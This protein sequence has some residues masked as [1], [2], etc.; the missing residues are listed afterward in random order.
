MRPSTRPTNHAAIATIESTTLN[1]LASTIG[2]RASGRRNRVTSRGC[3]GRSGSSI[4]NGCV[5]GVQR[6]RIAGR[7]Q[8]EPR[9]DL[10][11]VAH[12]R[13]EEPV[14]PRR[15]PSLDQQGEPG[16][17]N[18]WCGEESPDPEHDVVRHDERQAQQDGEPAPAQRLVSVNAKPG[19]GHAR[20]RSACEA[21]ILRCAVGARRVARLRRRGWHA[22]DEGGVRREGGRDLR[23]VQP[24]DQVVRESDEPLGS[25]NG[26]RQDAVRPRQGDRR[27]ARR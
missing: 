14:Q 20:Y 13:C 27:A 19:V 9:G 24:A 16:D 5:V 15:Q 8:V 7:E 12:E 23:Q 18:R 2:G 26:R 6:V 21:G 3:R 1:A 4:R 25:R 10:S 22:S 11:L 17:R